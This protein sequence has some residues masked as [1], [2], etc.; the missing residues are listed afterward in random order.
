MAL[1]YK[2]P[3]TTIT[4]IVSPSVSPQI[5]S[6]ATV[7][8]IGLSAG[9]QTTTDQIR[10]TGTTAIPLPS[11]PADATLQT[12]LSVKDALDP[13]K[14]AGDGSGYVLTTD[15]TVQTSG[16]TVTRVSGGA[17]ADGTIVNVT[18]KYVDA[19]YFDAVRMTDFPSVTTRFGQ[20]LNPDGTI[21]SILSFGALMAFENG[22]SELILQPLFA[23]ATPGDATTAKTQPDATAAAAT[24]TWQDT[25]IAIRG[26]EEINILIPL[27]GQSAT[28]VGDSTQLNILQAV[29][30]HVKYMSDN[31][32][33]I[34]A[35]FGEDSSAASNVA[36]KATLRSHA[37]TLKGR[38]GGALGQV[39]CL[40]SPSK[41]TRPRL[42][43]SNQPLYIG[44]QYLAAAIG[45]MI[46][47]RPVSEALTGDLV[48]GVT[49][50]VSDQ[51]LKLDKNTDAAAGL[52]VLEN[53]GTDNVYVR[54]GIT[55]DDTNSATRELSV[56]RAKHRMIE[57]IKST[58]DTQ[59]I[60][61]VVADENA[62]LLVRSAVGQ[63]LEA[64]RLSRDLVS[65]K[66]IEARIKTLE[67]TEVEVRFDYR[68]SFPLNY[69]TI[70]FSIDLNSGDL[71]LNTVSS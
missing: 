12:V 28:N 59:I 27:V 14:G 26:A 42:V 22:A 2:V 70:Q 36:T 20:P 44:G 54:H 53:R 68:P 69:I 47:S 50:V 25:L 58:L 10:L 39:T 18:Y 3:G 43:P 33:K 9:S 51:H 67:P 16:K 19:R 48:S 55:L 56:V 32:Q 37:T 21:N 49:S 60:G 8:L 24:T 41:F 64:L 63:V 5:A 65:Y 45:G 11:V 61:Q 13:S 71:D 31:D 52:M 34:V 40:V 23:R 15:Y 4:E 30:D 66:G 1:I 62:P 7:S 29:Q 17:I 57:S 38:Y 46:A 35:L 6:P